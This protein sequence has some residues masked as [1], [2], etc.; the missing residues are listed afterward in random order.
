MQASVN[1]EGEKLT[2]ND[3]KEASGAAPAPG[4]D[5]ALI[6]QVR[7]GDN[8]AFAG[9]Y[10]R[11]V[12]SAMVTAR[13][14]AR[15]PSDIP[16]LVAEAFA[17]VLEAI[18]AG[19]GPTVFFR[20]YLL[21]TL[22]R[23]ALGKR[24][25]DDKHVLM[26][27]LETV[28]APPLRTDP[29][30]TA[31]EHDVVGRSFRELPERWQ[32]VLWYSE[33]DGMTPAGMA[34]IMGISANAV[35]ALA[36][37]AREGLKQAYLQNHVSTADNGCSNYAGNLGS[38]SRG[39]LTRRRS[40][41]VRAHLQGCLRCTEA[42]LHLNDVGGGMR[43]VILPLFVGFSLA[44]LAT[45]QVSG[46][47]FGAGTVA[48]GG[49]TG[50]DAGAGAFGPVCTA[51]AT[52][53]VGLILLGGVVVAA[54]AKPP[55]VIGSIPASASSPSALA[56]PGPGGIL[57]G[58]ALP[59]PVVAVPTSSANPSESAGWLPTRDPEEPGQGDWS[60]PWQPWWLPLQV[61]TPAPSPGSAPAPTPSPQTPGQSASPAP[62]S[63]PPIPT[64]APT[65][66]S[67][68]ASLTPT[69]SPPIPT[70]APTTPAP[71]PTGSP[72][73]VKISATA[74][75]SRWSYPRAKIRVTL[76]HAGQTKLSNAAV[77]FRMQKYWVKMPLAASSRD[78]WECLDASS[79]MP[80]QSSCTAAS[81]SPGT[82]TFDLSVPTMSIV[83]GYPL[84]ISA[85]AVGSSDVTT[86]IVFQPPR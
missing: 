58:S 16:D 25:A 20:A 83:S 5:E 35:A 57:P 19:N 81:W 43:S 34:P 23:L 71:S 10:E 21:T 85:S 22:R 14:Y 31:F 53:A 24:A 15:N 74:S 38:Y 67:P 7:T 60:R 61:A 72:E 62:T 73:D 52:S 78:G 42:L 45:T 6:L 17:K 13:G 59:P 3:V 75:I 9:L 48:G 63:S 76:S 27:D 47:A 68:G 66:P 64:L 79:S 11:H 18:Q 49:T 12:G 32:A 39:G 33:V 84:V 40:A 26:D 86:S 8:E 30:I 2:R 77:T 70:V 54:V 1:E 65:T 37:R 29:A 4:G 69:P 46:V 82:A 50:T 28:M 51:V 56:P 55:L 36:V 44:G 80:G 41:Q